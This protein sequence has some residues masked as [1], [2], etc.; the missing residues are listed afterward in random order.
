M[1]AAEMA[2]L[3]NPTP[4]QE[5]MR[6]LMGHTKGFT[7]DSQPTILRTLDEQARVKIQIDYISRVSSKKPMIIS[8]LSTSEHKIV[9]LPRN[10]ITLYTPLVEREG[11]ISI[12]EYSFFKTKH[13]TEH[14]WPTILRAVSRIE[15]AQD[16]EF[17]SENLEEFIAEM[18]EWERKKFSH[19]FNAMY[20]RQKYG[21]GN[22]GTLFIPPYS[23]GAQSVSA[24]DLLKLERE[25]ERVSG[26]MIFD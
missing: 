5:L 26:R 12:A 1:T 9:G 23:S 10:I 18:N 3:P 8:F 20:N 25:I 15:R 6:R 14:K 4:S 19:A 2:R 21:E 17:P 22:D 7:S 11:K 13:V 24:I 16:D